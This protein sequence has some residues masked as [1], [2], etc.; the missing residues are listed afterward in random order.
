MKK[1]EA[2]K[3]VKE[4]RDKIGSKVMLTGDH[5]HAVR[6]GPLL[7]CLIPFWDYDRW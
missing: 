6:L 7:V 5:P 4:I 1:K 3:A 2:R